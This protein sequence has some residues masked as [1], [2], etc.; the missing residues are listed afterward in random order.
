M[1]Q[2]SQQQQANH[3]FKSQE[4]T[5]RNPAQMANPATQQQANLSTRPKV[6]SQDQTGQQNQ[7]PATSK[8]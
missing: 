5:S 4:K 7:Q 1:D 6:G 3:D 2:H 8:Q